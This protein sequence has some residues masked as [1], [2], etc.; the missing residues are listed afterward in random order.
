MKTGKNLV[1]QLLVAI[2]NTYHTDYHR[3]LILVTS[4]WDAGSSM[5][6]INRPSQN[7]VPVT[8]VLENAGIQCSEWKGLAYYGGPME[9]NRVQIVHTLD[10]AVANTRQITD[11]IGITNETSILAA[12]AANEGPRAWRCVVGQRIL[13]PGE[14]EG[15]MSGEHPWSDGHRWLTVPAEVNTVFGGSGDQQ[16][17]NGIELA[18]RK[19]IASWF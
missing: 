18:G 2:P 6:I 12:I 9:Q 19:E 7:Q 17:L 3:S 11:E 5:V 16:W 4:H 10:W 15:E 8:A 14:L 13:G 1:G